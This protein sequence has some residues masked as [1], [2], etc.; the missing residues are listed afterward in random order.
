MN[1]SVFTILHKNFDLGSTRDKDNFAPCLVYYLSLQLNAIH[2]HRQEQIYEDVTHF[3]HLWILEMCQPTSIGVPKG[4]ITGTLNVILNYLCKWFYLFE[5]MDNY[6]LTNVREFHTTFEC[7][8]FDF[9][10]QIENLLVD[11]LS[12]FVV[13]TCRYPAISAG[14]GGRMVIVQSPRVLQIFLFNILT[15]H[16]LESNWLKNGRAFCS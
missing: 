4:Q 3:T 5:S 9:W 15:A 10:L 1:Q 12:S 8:T 16:G 6:R 7:K 13:C 14:K 2:V 11:T